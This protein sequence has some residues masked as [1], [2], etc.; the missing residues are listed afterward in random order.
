MRPLH[1]PSAARQHVFIY[2]SAAISSFSLG[3]IGRIWF[4]LNLEKINF[5]RDFLNGRFINFT[6]V[7]DI[8]ALHKQILHNFDV[9]IIV[10][11]LVSTEVETI[12]HLNYSHNFLLFRGYLK[13]IF[14][15]LIANI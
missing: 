2:G 11:P 14:L 12:F 3:G 6:V 1:S 5:A 13:E 15:K 8:P 10:G 7:F 4:Y 9:I